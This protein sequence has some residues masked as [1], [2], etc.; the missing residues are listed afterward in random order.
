MKANNWSEIEVELI[1]SSYF[2]MLTRELLNQ[3]YSKAE[4]RRKLLPLLNNRSES[5]I[6]FKHQNISAVLIKL[7]QPYIQGY[8]PRYKYQKILEDK[9]IEYLTG[10]PTIESA[11]SNFVS[12]E[13]VEP[14]LDASIFRK[15]LVDAPKLNIVTEPSPVYGRNPIK[16]NYLEREQQNAKLGELGEKFVLAYEKWR[17]IEAGKEALADKVIWISK[18]EGDGAGFDILSK[19]ENGTDRYVE[20]K[21][22]RLGKETPFYFSKNELQFSQSKDRSYHLFRLFDF[23]ANPRLFIKNGGLNEICH[24]EPISYKGYF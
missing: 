4:H 5:A 6:E 9:V 19:N 8:L 12:K 11:I 10:N 17:L 2:E 14:Q 20:V 13:I 22:T 15:A 21:T 16:I 23:K 24:S 7:G 18:E 3:T 1:V